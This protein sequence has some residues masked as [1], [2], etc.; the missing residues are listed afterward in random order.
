RCQLQQLDEDLLVLA[1]QVTDCNAA[2]F[3]VANNFKGCIPGIHE[4][5]RRQGIF[6]GIW[7][8]DPDE[9]LGP[10]Q[11]EEIDRVYR[12]YPNLNDDQFIADNLDRWLSS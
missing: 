5:I 3:D 7:C 12:S 11:A 4:I 1:G 9:T 2:F 10:G 6:E 8:L